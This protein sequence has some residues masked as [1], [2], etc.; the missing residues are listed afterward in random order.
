MF[1]AST[2]KFDDE[3]AGAS[4]RA[5]ERTLSKLLVRIRA[6]NF[7]TFPQEVD[8]IS[9]GTHPASVFAFRVKCAF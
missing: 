4:I 5:R 7:V 9:T 6:V 2:R 1:D 8:E 3:S